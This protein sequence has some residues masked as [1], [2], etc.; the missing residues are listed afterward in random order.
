MAE[1]PET[2]VDE[3]LEAHDG[4]DRAIVLAIV[5]TTL[6]AAI[7]GLGQILALQRHDESIA[8]ADQWASAASQSNYSWNSFADLQLDRFRL[9]QDAQNRAQVAHSDQVLRVDPGTGPLSEQVTQW[10]H[11]AAALQDGS[12]ALANDPRG[13]AGAAG[14]LAAISQLS[15][16]ST[17]D[18]STGSVTRPVRCP[19]VGSVSLGAAAPAAITPNGPDGPLRD[20]TF[21]RRYLADARGR[22]YAAQAAGVLAS[23]YAQDE[24][25]AFTRFGVSLTVLATAVFLF[26]FSLS[27]YGK[28]HRH[29]YSTVGAIFV[30]GATAW[31]TYAA[32]D[33]PA[34]ANPG[35]ATAYAAARVASDKGDFRDIQL[36]IK[37]D[38]CAERLDPAFAPAYTALAVEKN[39][40]TD[41]QDPTGEGN[42]ELVDSKGALANAEASITRAESLGLKNPSLD[43]LDGADVFE[44]GLR[45]DDVAKM[46]RGLALEQAA[47]QLLWGSTAL[48]PLVQAATTGSVALPNGAT[49][50]AILMLG[51]TTTIAFNIAEGQLGLGWVRQ[52]QASYRAAITLSKL[53]LE[54][55]GATTSAA[56]DAEGQGTV[57]STLTDLEDVAQHLPSLAA[58]ARADENLVVAAFSG[59]SSSKP[60]PPTGLTLTVLPTIAEFRVEHAG[61]L[62]PDSVSAQWYYR[63]TGASPWSAFVGPPSGE[64]DKLLPESAPGTYVGM[65]DFSAESGAFDPVCLPSGEYRLQLYVNGKILADAQQHVDVLATQPEQLQDIGVTLCDPVHAGQPWTMRSVPGLPAAAEAHDG[66]TAVLA[67]DVTA[68]IDPWNE[69][70]RSLDA[71]LDHIVNQLGSVLP[72][73]LTRV[74][75]L[76]Y[77]FLGQNADKAVEYTYP[78]G[79]LVAGIAWGGFGRAVVVVARG[80]SLVSSRPDPGSRQTDPGPTPMVESLLA[81]L[82]FDN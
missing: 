13:L 50:H 78:G 68:E 18:L 49:A 70:P 2:P 60:A 26:G 53:Q 19:G 16:L 1:H 35:A 54:A 44:D 5:I 77:D 33:A 23:E 30:V 79:Q 34:T 42:I 21:P 6:L 14:Q 81:S 55:T 40:L 62:R 72:G 12:N 65:T 46:A 43:E 74:G 73:P 25:R 36:A 56:V 80:P 28:S 17:P 15:Q 75:V 47:G 69:T 38:R 71:R 27:P 66:T 8:R 82:E 57:G 51:D 10:N 20:P 37:L 59:R 63:P 64:P 24:E 61:V 22:A 29:L 45:S 76:P 32:I 7:T 4:F 11:V 48:Q 52:A 3:M 9:V 39:S 67:F 31:A 41:P 58:A